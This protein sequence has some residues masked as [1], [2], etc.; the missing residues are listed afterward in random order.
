MERDYS[1]ECLVTMPRH[2]LEE[3]SM[4]ILTRM[5]PED[6]MSELFTFENEETDNEERMKAAQ[7]DAMLR[8]SAIALGQVILAFEESDNA[9]QNIQRM[10]RLLLWHFYAISFN[11]EKAISLEVH[12][13]KVEE[14]LQTPPKDALAWVK[15]L[16]ELL[17]YYAEK[18]DQSE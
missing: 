9:K 4:R 7:F 8:M 15:T 16:T 5:V 17:H 14:I 3:F 10:S 11:L 13:A 2:E 12:C 18:S 6:M 1:F